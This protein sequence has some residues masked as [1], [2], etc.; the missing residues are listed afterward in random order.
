MTERKLKR[1]LGTNG[2]VTIKDR[3]TTVGWYLKPVVKKTKKI[4][5]KSVEVIIIDDDP[6]PMNTKMAQALSAFANWLEVGSRPDWLQLYLTVWQAFDRKY[7]IVRKSI[8]KAGN[9]YRNLILKV[10]KSSI[11]RQAWDAGSSGDNCVT[12][13]YDDGIGAEIE[14][15]TTS[16]WWVINTSTPSKWLN[17]WTQVAYSHEVPNMKLEVLKMITTTFEIRW[18]NTTQRVEWEY[19]GLKYKLIEQQCEAFVEVECV[20]DEHEGVVTTNVQ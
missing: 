2:K 11:K 6:Q 15:P 17:P 19:G 18:T 12:V 20:F 4:D 16:W 1:E 10:R 13:W 3:L 9:R 8:C 14:M 5:M 7:G